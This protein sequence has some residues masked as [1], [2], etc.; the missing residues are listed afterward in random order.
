MDCG[1]VKWIVAHV[2]IA[3]A[4]S[5]MASRIMVLKGHGNVDTMNVR[6][7]GERATEGRMYPCS[8]TARHVPNYAPIYVAMDMWEDGFAC[9]VCHVFSS[10]GAEPLLTYVAGSCQDCPGGSITLAARYSAVRPPNEG[11]LT[12]TRCP[13]SEEGQALDVVDQGPFSTIDFA[14]LGGDAGNVMAVKV[15]S[16]DGWE[17]LLH[18]YAAMFMLYGHSDDQNI[19]LSLTDGFQ[20]ERTYVCSRRTS[21]LDCIQSSRGHTGR[22]PLSTRPE[23][24]RSFSVRVP[25]S[26]GAAIP[27]LSIR[28][29]A[30]SS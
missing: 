3:C 4:A 12:R 21:R 10:Q 9:G 30:T 5:L 1:R 13:A 27:P 18:A 26:G 7:I 25:I 16:Q 15:S 24:P 29:Q 20:A 8:A 28:I 11:T 14:P 2:M 17:H 23:P 19:Y 6:F 22:Q